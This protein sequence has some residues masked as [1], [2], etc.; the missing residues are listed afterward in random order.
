MILEVFW[1]RRLGGRSHRLPDL[2][3][4]SSHESCPYR[5]NSLEAGGWQA[6]WAGRLA[7]WLD[8]LDGRLITKF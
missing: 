8:W 3:G 6:G 4:L 1:T 5:K 2:R 7:G